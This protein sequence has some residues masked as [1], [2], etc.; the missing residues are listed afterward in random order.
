VQLDRG[1]AALRSR[2]AAARPSGRKP[3]SRCPFL[4]GY[5]M[6]TMCKI[7]RG[8]ASEDTLHIKKIDE[9]LSDR[10]RRVSRRASLSVHQVN[11]GT[12]YAQ[13]VRCRAIAY[14]GVSIS[15]QCLEDLFQK[16]ASTGGF[17]RANASHTQNSYLFPRSEAT[18]KVHS[19]LVQRVRKHARLRNRLKH[20][21]LHSLRYHKTQCVQMSHFGTTRGAELPRVSILSLYLILKW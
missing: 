17:F 15:V 11:S 7:I 19:R 21:D 3:P 14:A 16:V 9:D 5:G 1:G 10:D 13:S 2:S 18:R 20:N 6:L 8:R 12:P 4:Y